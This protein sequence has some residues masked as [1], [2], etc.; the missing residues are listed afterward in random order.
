MIFL[1]SSYEQ[2]RLSIKGPCFY[3]KNFWPHKVKS[4]YELNCYK[5]ALKDLIF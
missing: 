3:F 1:D 5:I 4:N 2:V